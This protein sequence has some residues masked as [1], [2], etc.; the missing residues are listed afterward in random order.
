MARDKD[1]WFKFFGCDWRGDPN[2]QLCS[3]AAR[4]LWIEIMCIMQTCTPYG[5]LTLD[6]TPL[7]LRNLAVLVHST[8]GECD[9]LLKQMREAK[10]FSETDAGVIFSRRMVRDMHL[11]SIRAEAGSEGGKASVSSRF[12]QANVSS[13]PSR[14]R[15]RALASGSLV[16]GT[17]DSQGKEEDCKGEEKPKGPRAFSPETES[18]YLIAVQCLTDAG[19]KTPDTTK[20][21]EAAKNCLR[22]MIEADGVSPDQIRAGWEAVR[23]DTGNGGKWPG[24]RA[25]IQSVSGFRDKWPKFKKLIEKPEMAWDGPPRPERAWDDPGR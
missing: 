18:L 24:W 14:T 3:L 11:R 8:E 9:I 25:I 19:H 13:N 2:L 1:S 17:L 15:G 22:L 10:V 20:R 21:I 4:G 12:A 5:H 23:L 7:S 6:G 16:S